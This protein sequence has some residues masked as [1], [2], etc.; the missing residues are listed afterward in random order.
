MNDPNKTSSTFSCVVMK[1]GRTCLFHDTEKVTSFVFSNLGHVK[2]I[3]PASSPLF[4]RTA[5]SGTDPANE[6]DSHE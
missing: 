5:S 2:S 6:E 1:D 4:G 3:H